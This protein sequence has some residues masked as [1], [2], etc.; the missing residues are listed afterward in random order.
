MAREIDPGGISGESYVSGRYETY[1]YNGDGTL[2]KVTD[3]NGVVKTYVYDILKRTTEETAAKGGET[4]TRSYEYDGNGNLTGASNGSQYT[5]TRTYDEMNRVKT[6]S[7]EGFGTSKYEYD[8]QMEEGIGERS[9]DPSGNEVEREY[10]KLGR[11]IRVKDGAAESA[12]RYRYDAAGRIAEAVQETGIRTEYTYDGNNQVQTAKQYKAGEGEPS[13]E[14]GYSY[15]NA[16]NMTQ[17]TSSRTQATTYTY[18]ALNRLLTETVA[19][20]SS[21]EEPVEAQERKFTYTYDAAGN[22]LQEVRK[23]G[24]VEEESAYSYDNRNRLTGRTS[25]RGNETYGYDNNGNMTTITRSEGTQAFSYD[26]YSQMV[27]ATD[28]T[29]A[30]G[31]EFSY[32]AEGRLVAENVVGETAERKYLYE[33]GNIILE[34]NTDGTE[35][36]NLY[37]HGLLL[38]EEG[39]SAS[40]EIIAKHSLE[41]EYGEK[42]YY[43]GDGT[44][45]IPSHSLFRLPD[46]TSF[47]RTGFPSCALL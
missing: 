33:G 37:G 8:I 1:E 3:R 46:N 38:R 15:D 29:G 14:T 11:L 18:D 2:N 24:G 35:T 44:S 27:S 28:K 39:K 42:K 43:Q 17:K 7:A 5:V 21:S 40:A 36:R 19:G 20:E 25:P 26:L 12:A 34:K 10:D 30:G 45:G 32:D 16:G 9:R 47:P 6:K 31:K 4:E 23:E 13:E 22:R 41:I